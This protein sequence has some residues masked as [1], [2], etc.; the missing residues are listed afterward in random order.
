MID[1]RYHIVSIVAVFLAL[2]LGLFLGSTTLQGTVLNGINGQVKRVTER[3]NV[4]TGQLAQAQSQLGTD[5]SFL[6]ALAPLAVHNLLTGQSVALISA[7]GVSGA[8]TDAVEHTLTSAG[9]TVSSRVQVEPGLLDPSQSTLL[10]SLANRLR[11]AS[12]NLP[13]A[14]GSQRAAA[15]LAAVLATRPSRPTLPAAKAQSVLSSFAAAKAITVSGGVGN[16]H[17]ADLAVFLAPAPAD[18]SAGHRPADTALL[19]GIADDLAHSCVGTVLA[20]P[21][22]AAG[23]GGVLEQARTAPSRPANLATVQASDTIAGQVAVAY[24]LVEVFSGR[25]GDFGPASGTPLPAPSPS[26]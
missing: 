9:A 25:S 7:P 13:A 1:F 22:A 5:D 6:Q 15:E 14:G 11:P 17:P 20:G 19:T 26:S 2:A 23:T 24:G 4:L 18:L 8:T 3:N 12:V 21:A 16:V 10:G